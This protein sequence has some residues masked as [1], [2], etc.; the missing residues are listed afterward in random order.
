M[1]GIVRVFAGL[2]EACRYVLLVTR[3][4]GV[5]PRRSKR[6]LIIALGH[7]LARRYGSISRQ[8]LISAVAIDDMA[9]VFAL[10]LR[11]LCA[12]TVFLVL[13]PE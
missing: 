2:W 3:C 6:V 7:D 8:C 10:S 1:R 9:W 11:P 4:H 5:R 13:P 12:E